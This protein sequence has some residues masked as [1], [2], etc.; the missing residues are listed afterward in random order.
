MN[1]KLLSMFKMWKLYSKPL[2]ELITELVVVEGKKS[3]NR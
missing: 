1:S 3:G 2:S